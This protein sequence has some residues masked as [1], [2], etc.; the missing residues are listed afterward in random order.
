MMHQVEIL[1]ITLLVKA[2]KSPFGDFLW[3]IVSVSGQYRQQW[4][5]VCADMTENSMEIVV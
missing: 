4:M 3:L 5:P 1:I 2:K